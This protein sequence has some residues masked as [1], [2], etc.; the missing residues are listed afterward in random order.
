VAR[1][2]GPSEAPEML[3]PQVEGGLGPSGGPDEDD[4]GE[5]AP[6]HIGRLAE[7]GRRMAVVTGTLACLAGVVA[8]LVAGGIVAG[9]VG[10]AIAGALLVVA[11]PAVAFARDQWTLTTKGREFAASVED[12][13]HLK[14][15]DAAA[16]RQVFNLIFPVGDKEFDAEQRRAS[17][18]LPIEHGSAA[19]SLERSTP[20]TFWHSLAVAERQALIAVARERTFS[21]GAV[22]VRAGQQ[23]DHVILLQSGVTKV[24]VDRFGGERIVALRGPGELIGERAAL[25]V[26]ERS[27]T[28]IALDNV[29]A[30][31]I[32]T[33]DFRWFLGVHPRL[34]E[35]I[36]GQLYERLTEDRRPVVSDAP[37][38]IEEKL[39]LQI[40]D[41]MLRQGLG[42][43]SAA[44]AT[45]PVTA[46]ELARWVHVPQPSVERVLASW[47]K[48][49]VARPAQGRLAVND[50]GELRRICGE[51]SHPSRA[52]EAS[53]R[54]TGQNCSILL[55]D[56]AGFGAHERNDRDREIVR[57]AM[58]ELLEHACEGSGVPWGVCHREDRGDGTLLVVPPG[59]PTASVVDPLLLHLAAGLRRHNRQAGDPTRMQLR[60][61]LD[62][63]PVVSDA[64][65]VTGHAIISAARLLDAPVLKQR[66]ADTRADLGFVA[67]EFVYL[68]VIKHAGGHVDPAGYERVRVRTKETRVSAWMYVTGGEAGDSTGP[69]GD[70]AGHSTGDSRASRLARGLRQGPKHIKRRTPARPK[71]TARAGVRRLSRLIQSWS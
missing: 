27:A 15:S 69:A 26:S 59:T 7:M 50:V 46:R 10:L 65:G 35:V 18:R 29:Q 44:T 62:V 63:G 11:V 45:L 17:S 28:V 19:T 24:C 64:D 36:E 34:L 12:V 51:A 58:Y 14:G 49:G 48:R 60:V 66:L 31:V 57:R 30:L 21:A 3:T 42:A 6:P 52:A 56:I 47:R 1:L 33:A 71:Q 39:A 2:T 22:L 40:L 55:T 68:H 54:L 70:S 37:A 43:D 32:D 67:S 13:E 4:D 20:N 41:L 38:D 23:A 53:P 5:A 16:F 61:A 9:P 8:I 25:R